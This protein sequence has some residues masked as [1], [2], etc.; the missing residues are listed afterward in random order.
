MATFDEF[1]RRMLA[2]VAV[3]DQA[4]TDVEQIETAALAEWRRRQPGR[5]NQ[6]AGPTPDEY[7]IGRMADGGRYTVACSRR[8]SAQQRI[9]MWALAALVSRP[10]LAPRGSV[11]GGDAP[12]VPAG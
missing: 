8:A 12:T 11:G 7:A 10:D 5:D 3:Y 4:Q 1:R 2:A 6:S 9:I